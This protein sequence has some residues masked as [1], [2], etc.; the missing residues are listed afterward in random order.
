MSAIFLDH[1]SSTPVL[2]AAIEAMKPFWAE[3]YGNPSSLH[4]AGLKAREALAKARGQFA[5]F[6]RA[7]NPEDIIFTSGGTEAANLA[8]KGVAWANARRGKHLVVSA[9][10]HPAVLNSI[11]FLEQHGFTATRVAVDRSGFIDPEAIREAL[12]D[13][14]ILICVHQANYDVGTIQP[15]RQI[16]EVANARGMPLFVDAV[17]S[18][19]WLPIDVQELGVSLLSLSAHRFYGPKGA[20]ILYRNRRVRLASLIHGGDQERGLRAGTEN[21]AALVG[22]G[23]AAEAAGHALAERSAHVS[24]L[25]ERLWA[26]LRDNVS[27][28]AL[29]GPPPGPNRLTTN[30]NVSAEFTEGEGVL[31]SLDMTG[32]QVAGGTSCVSKAIKVSP[33]LRAMGV[34]PSLAQASI[35]FTLGKDNTAPEIDRAAATYRRVVEKLRGMSPLWEEFQAGMIKSVVEPRRTAAGQNIS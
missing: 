5:A 33:V 25:Q 23:V 21:V 20:G 31:L 34:D 29:H 11:D 7:E 10:E 17:A 24:Q 35:T 30:L 26:A 2:E 14:T 8:V 12:R 27:Y 3:R 4:Q 18:A 15:L 19:G 28:L 16:A 22:A 13:D 32:I 9:I 1:Q 6:I